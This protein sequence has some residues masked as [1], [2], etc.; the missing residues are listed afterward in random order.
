MVQSVGER[1]V[2]LVPT[3]SPKIF[4]APTFRKIQIQDG[5]SQGKGHGN[6]V[7]QDGGLTRKKLTR[8]SIIRMHCIGALLL[9]KSLS[10]FW[11]Y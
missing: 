4:L 9:P 6:D 3:R 7:V 2:G 10:C 5:P 1:R 11:R 8:A